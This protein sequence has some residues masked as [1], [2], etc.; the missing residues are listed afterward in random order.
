[1]RTPTAEIS[2]AKDSR[3]WDFAAASPTTIQCLFGAA[4]F[5]IL[6]HRQLSE[7]ANLALGLR[8]AS[9]ISSI[10]FL[11]F[12]VLLICIRSL[13][14]AKAAGLAPRLWAI[15]GS[16]FSYLVL[17]LPKIIPTPTESIL[18]SIL[19]LT[20]TAASIWV[21]TSLRRGFSIFPQ[22][23]VLVTTGPYRIVRHPLYLAEQISAFGIALQFQQPLGILI[24]LAGFFLQFP[25]MHYEETVLR[26]S[27]PSYHSYFSHTR[28][29]IPFVY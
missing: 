9:E 3:L 11:L 10:L 16:T 19:I 21:L 25:R 27:F 4:G 7:H 20:G 15:L 8:I 6:I 2:H 29:I 28:R 5:A 24:V 17:L 26:A 1:M 23:R 14:S 12:Q 18:S 22:A 13:P